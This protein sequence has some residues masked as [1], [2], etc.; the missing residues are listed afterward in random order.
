MALSCKS[1]VVLSEQESE[2]EAKIS[3]IVFQSRVGHYLYE[4]SHEM[5][6]RRGRMQRFILG[7]K[8]AVRETVAAKLDGNNNLLSVQDDPGQSALLNTSN[9]KPTKRENSRI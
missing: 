9:E 2:R 8:N 1:K 4:S 3:L 6:S 7:A 5:Q